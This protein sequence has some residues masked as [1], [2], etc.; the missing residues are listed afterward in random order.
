L[1]LS[2]G[3]SSSLSAASLTA[4][5]LLG[6]MNGITGGS[7]LQSNL[8]HDAMRKIINEHF[9]DSEGKDNEP[10][11][12]S[13]KN[14]RNKFE[15]RLIEIETESLRVA[16]ENFVLKQLILDSKQKQVRFVVFGRVA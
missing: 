13:Q 14:I 1:F 9:R 11:S 8:P 3:I 7:Q 16:R 15:K 10:E 12:N 5:T 2:I 4:A 6:N